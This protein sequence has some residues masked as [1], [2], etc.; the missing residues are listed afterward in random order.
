MISS[1]M[2]TNMPATLQTTMPTTMPVRISTTIPKTMPIAIPALMS[3]TTPT[4][5]P[6][7]RPRTDAVLPKGLSKPPNL[8]VL[9]N[10]SSEIKKGS[11]DRKGNLFRQDEL[12]SLLQQWLSVWDT[13]L[14]FVIKGH[15]AEKAVVV[16]LN[17]VRHDIFAEKF[18]E[19]VWK[20]N[21]QTVIKLLK[22]MHAFQKGIPYKKGPVRKSFRVR[23]SKE[24]EA[25]ASIFRSKTS[26]GCEKHNKNAQV[27]LS[28]CVHILNGIAANQIDSKT[29]DLMNMLR[30]IIAQKSLPS[31]AP[32]PKKSFV[33][34]SL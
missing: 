29:R 25:N 4:M 2:P 11:S 24:L 3:N 28:S 9:C 34:M 17:H 13:D 15:V 22:Q 18:R 16:F 12:K 6:T 32:D 23:L 10:V 31:S 7:K 19:N 5:M 30:N 8:E 33:Y 26:T 20:Q 21:R 27:A 14:P 1:T